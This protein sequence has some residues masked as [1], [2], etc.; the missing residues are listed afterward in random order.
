MN[1]EQLFETTM[2]PENRKLL[3]RLAFVAAMSADWE[4]ALDHL[5][6]F[7]AQPGRESANR[8]KS[9]LSLSYHSGWTQ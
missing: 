6:R 2:D 1:P 3:V 8:L 7:L 5:D 9:G 4:A